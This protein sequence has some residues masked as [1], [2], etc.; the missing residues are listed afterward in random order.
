MDEGSARGLEQ[1]ISRS[2]GVHVSSP[3]TEGVIGHFAFLLTLRKGFGR[4]G[5]TPDTIDVVELEVGE[6]S[7]QRKSIA[8]VTTL[9][10]VEYKD[11][12]ELETRPVST[13]A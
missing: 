9:G 6:G 4:N 8:L 12:F 1:G 3:G 10:H 7:G 5:F 11:F 2:N 13:E